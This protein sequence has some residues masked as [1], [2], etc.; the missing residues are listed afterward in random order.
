MQAKLF[1]NQISLV[2]YLK[3]AEIVS[4]K[5]CH[6]IVNLHNNAAINFTQVLHYKSKCCIIVKRRSQTAFY[7]YKKHKRWNLCHLP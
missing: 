5:I 3:A 7:P 6:C 2:I 4:I 1:F